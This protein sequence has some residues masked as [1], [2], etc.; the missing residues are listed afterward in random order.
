MGANRISEIT[1]NLYN[2][3]DSDVAEYMVPYARK[4][5]E[6]GYDDTYVPT[7][8]E[9][10]GWYIGGGSGVVLL[11]LIILLRRGRQTDPRDKDQRLTEVPGQSNRK[12]NRKIVIAASSSVAIC[13][14]TFGV[15][16]YQT[17]SNER[18]NLENQKTS[19]K[20]SQEE[21]PAEQLVAESE[22]EP[23][24][25]SAVEANEEVVREPEQEST[26]ETAIYSEYTD[27]AFIAFYEDTKPVYDDLIAN[28]NVAEQN[29][30]NETQ[31]VIDSAERLKV[32]VSTDILNGQFEFAR[33]GM[34]EDLNKLIANLNEKSPPYEIIQN[35]QDIELNYCDILSVTIQQ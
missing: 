29:N 20:T 34:I 7:F 24:Q 23:V 13:T 6:M 19:E 8:W 4:A 10:Y 26:S 11:L 1:D 31:S 30:S 32:I 16:K 18:G 2:D 5:Y 28:F 21:E 22:E 15:I 12:F 14:I 27:P 33:Q 25:E 17:D 35:V 9:Q 3:M